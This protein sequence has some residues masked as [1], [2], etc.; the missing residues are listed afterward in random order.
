MVDY[1]PWGCRVRHDLATKP[2]P[3]SGTLAVVQRCLVPREEGL[4]RMQGKLLGAPLPHAEL[5]QAGQGRGGL[6]G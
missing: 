1:S 2:P 5:E 6:G 4:P 3:T